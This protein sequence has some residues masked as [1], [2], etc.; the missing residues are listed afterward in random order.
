M[1]EADFTA[2][3]LNPDLPVPDGLVDA[4]GRPAGRR[5]SVYRNNVAS[6]LTDALQTAFPVLEKLLGTDYFKALAGVFLRAHPPKSRVMMLYGDALPGFLETFP[7]LAHLPYLADVARLEQALREAYHAA[8]ADPIA[9]DVLAGLPPE[10]FIAARLR[11]APAMRLIVSRYPVHSI[12]RANREADAPA[13]Q[14][15][16]EAVLVLRPG[17]DPS[18]HVLP[19]GGAAF[20]TCLLAGQTVGMALEQATEGFDLNTLLAM[21]I[22]GGAIVDLDEETP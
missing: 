3:L 8:D 11:F 1:T 21:L 5:F 18:P 20:L 9:T 10:R 17:Y 2:A 12:W 19:D 22:G 7:P 14:M 4:Q 15:R 6:S 13:P 16:A